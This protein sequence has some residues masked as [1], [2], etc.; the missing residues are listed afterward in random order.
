[1]MANNYEFN[2]VMNALK[3][4]DKVGN[5]ED[6]QKLAAIADRLRKSQPIQLS[7]E[8]KPF[9]SYINKGIATSVGAPMDI[10]NVG[11]KAIGLGTEEPFGGSKSIER[12]MRAIGIDVPGEK[13]KTTLEFIG[14]G[15]G[16][17]AGMLLPATATFKLLSRGTG[18]VPKLSKQIYTTMIKHPVATGVSEVTGGIG[19]GAGRKVGEEYPQ[20]GATPEIVGGM[21]GSMA[22]TALSYTPT[23][24]AIKAGKKIAER[25]SL[26][27]TE[28]GAKYRAGEFIKKQVAEPSIVAETLAKETVS[29]LPPVVITGEKRLMALYNQIRSLDLIKDAKVIDQISK[30][31]IKLEQEMRR[32]GRGSPEILRDLTER[33]IASIELGMD[34][35]VQERLLV[36]QRKIDSLPVAQRQ[37]QESIIVR[38]ELT[39]VMHEEYDLVKNTWLDVPKKATVGVKN[40]QETFT[41]ISEELASA[42]KSDIPSV[43]RNHPVLG[44]DVTETT[45]NEMQGLRSKLLEVSRQARSNNQWN[46]ARISDDIA[47]AI[48][49]DMTTSAEKIPTDEGDLL[50]TA[51]AATKKF[52]QRFEQGTVGKILGYD[53][54]SAPSIAPELTL[55][56]ATKGKAIVDINKVV[57][58]PEA[59]RATEKYIARSFTDYSLDPNGVVNPIKAQKFIRN[60]EELLD[61]FPNL[62]TQLSDIGEAQKLANSTKNIMEARKAALRDPRIS[63]AGRFLNA[64]IGDEIKSIL[65][66]P[67]PTMTTNQLVKQARKDVTGQAIEGLRGG[68]VEHILDNS[69][70]GGFNDLGERTLSGKAILGFMKDNR[71]VVNQVFSPEQIGRMN[72]IGQELSKLETLEKTKGMGIEYSDTVSNILKFASRFAGAAAGRHWGK[73]VGA[74]GT[75]QIPGFFAQQWHKV[76]SKLTKQRFENLINDA[77]MS[78]DKKLLET[79]LMPIEKPTIKGGRSEEI[80]IRLNAWLMATGNRV[81]QDIVTE[82]KQGE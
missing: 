7:K 51:L 5:I 17:T 43:L 71:N 27:F 67:N 70:I 26:P 6:A 25:V 2:D 21:V 22:P 78:P 34:N 48:F 20:L 58:T 14:S 40:T 8:S 18:L 13:P 75:V 72:R 30:A 64:N 24:L 74:G 62:R 1:M 32:L 76:V 52:K 36:A 29:D 47:D 46:K 56:I 81:F 61:S 55:D 15:V 44:K 60:N 82:E 50:K 49:E 31:A 3:E 35:R 23:R 45:L 11:F 16:E 37:S 41:K 66:S 57:I 33:R 54:T 38:N 42:Q 19:M 73:M 39:K 10:A 53:R 79:L 63:A 69:S 9:M 68:F 28:A 4:A 59:K 65:K 12:G 77:I 80:G